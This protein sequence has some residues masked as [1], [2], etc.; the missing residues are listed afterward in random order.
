MAHLCRRTLWFLSPPIRP[1]EL[2]SPPNSRL[3]SK[4]LFERAW[5]RRNSLRKLRRK[6]RQSPR[7]WFRYP[8]KWNP[9][10]KIERRVSRIGNHHAFIIFKNQRFSSAT[11][12]TPTWRGSPAT[13]LAIL[14]DVSHSACQMIKLAVL[15]TWRLMELSSIMNPRL[16]QARSPNFLAVKQ[17]VGLCSA[18]KWDAFLTLACSPLLRVGKKTLVTTSNSV[19]YSYLFFLFLLLY[20]WS[21]RDFG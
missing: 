1:Y 6:A 18:R 16:I 10:Y 17:G 8:Q 21:T 12:F 7:M 3:L 13:Y 11:I 20:G 2:I 14:P 9:G 19:P 5:R 4:K 15:E